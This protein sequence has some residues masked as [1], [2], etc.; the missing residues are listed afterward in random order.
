MALAL[1]DQDKKHLGELLSTALA[2]QTA[3]LSVDREVHADH[4]QYIQVLLGREERQRVRR[5]KIRQQVTGWAVITFLSG[6]GL[7]VYRGLMHALH[8]GGGG[9]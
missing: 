1:T 8:N 4:H 9:S 7:A 3:A 6:I 5:E 2:E